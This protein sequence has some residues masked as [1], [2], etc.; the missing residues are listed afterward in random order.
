MRAARIS[1]LGKWLGGIV[2]P[3]LLAHDQEARIVPS[4]SPAF[5]VAAT[6]AA[7]K[8]CHS[9]ARSSRSAGL[10]SDV[11]L[12]RAINKI[13]TFGSCARMSRKV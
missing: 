4:G 12:V 1:R 3:M 7:I 6:C 2:Q 10:A 5:N 9:R 13:S 8:R 11:A